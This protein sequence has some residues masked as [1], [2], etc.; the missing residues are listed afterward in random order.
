MSIETVRVFLVNDNVGN[1]P[2]EGVLVRV[3]N[4]AG[5]ALIT[6]TS[7]DAQGIADFSLECPA[8]YKVRFFKERF[9]VSQPVAM[10][11]ASPFT[12]S[13]A[14]IVVGHVYAPPE[15]V[16]PRMCRCSGF[17]RNVNNS[18]AASVDVHLIAKFNPLLLEGNAM[19]TERLRG[20]TDETGY[21]E[22]DL[23]RCGQYD[24][25]VEGMEDHL[26]TVSVPDAPSANLPDLLFP[27]VD[28]ITFSPAGPWSIGVGQGSEVVITP[29]IYTSDGRL[30]EG[31]SIEDVLWSTETPGIAAVI[32]SA[33]TLTLRG[34]APG[35]TSLLATRLDQSIVRIPATPIAGVPVTVT[36][37]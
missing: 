7:T 8:A 11:T 30:L 37:V 13:N 29:S 2:V 20:R 6:Q 3:F 17:F 32:P 19:L 26:R 9:F 15:A 21:L 14:F 10:V 12:A 18:P 5:S 23:V 28:R 31:T 36:V 24:V 22:V 27:V 4:S 34:I 16:H 25:T 35:S 33:T 1:S